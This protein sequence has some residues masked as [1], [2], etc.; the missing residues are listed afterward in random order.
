[1]VVVVVMFA[2]ELV[3]ESVLASDSSQ[4]C[5]DV[6]DDAVLLEARVAHRR[7]HP[8]RHR[9][10]WW[11]Q[12]AN[13]SH[14]S[15]SVDDRDFAK[16]LASMMLLVPAVEPG[17][18]LSVME[19]DCSIS[20]VS[21]N[22]VDNRDSAVAS[23][24]SLCRRLAMFHDTEFVVEVVAALLQRRRRHRSGWWRRTANDRQVLISVDDRDCAK[25]L[26]SMMLLVPAV[27]PGLM[28]SVTEL[29]C[30]ISNVS[31]IRVDDRDSAVVS[32]P[33]LCR[34]LAMLH[35]T[36]F[37]V[38]V[39]A[40]QRSQRSQRRRRHRS[41]W[42]RRTANGWRELESLEPASSNARGN[43]AGVHD[44]SLAFAPLPRR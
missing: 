18:M 13:D 31:E 37:V 34:R 41:G 40:T 30:S 32:T 8:R 21:E 11:R 22:I 16:S 36:E 35:D 9:W 28:A 19:L 4:P 43:D 2:S 20:N 3:L 25:S 7:C 15:A 39:V 42:W 23:T 29:D 12:T 44:P 33:S 38:E 26:A 27:E 24:P 5:V 17:L 10:D 6:L 1:V 14:A